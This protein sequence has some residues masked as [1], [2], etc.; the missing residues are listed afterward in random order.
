MPPLP[1]VKLMVSFS[2][3]LKGGGKKI[4]SHVW[5][6][7]PQTNSKP[8]FMS[9]SPFPSPLRNFDVCLPSWNQNFPHFFFQIHLTI[10]R[11]VFLK[12]VP[13]FRRKIPLRSQDEKKGYCTLT[14]T[15]TP[16]HQR[17]RDAKA[18]EPTSSSSTTTPF[19][20]S[21]HQSSCWSNA[22][23]LQAAPD[24]GFIRKASW[25]LLM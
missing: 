17:Q 15:S 14:I 4:T 7:R 13:R 16:S 5:L 20:S 23:L 11:V 12:N 9:S 24:A 6:G 3:D 1:P 2:R 18:A 22:G 21:R 8:R 19:L 10:F 25:S